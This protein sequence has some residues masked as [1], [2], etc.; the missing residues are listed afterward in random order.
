MITGLDRVPTPSAAPRTDLDSE[1]IERA[2]KGDTTALNRLVER[3]Y[4]RAFN[5]ALRLTGN[6]EDA[7]DVVSEA[8]IRVWR[9]L[10]RFEGHSRFTTW[11]YAVV[12]NVFL[13]HYKRERLRAHCSLEALV[14]PEG[15]SLAPQIPDPHPGPQEHV[16]ELDVRKRVWGAVQRLPE[17]YRMMIVLYHFQNLEYE[18]I[19]RILEMPVGTV[20]SRMHRA[21]MVLKTRI[22]RR[23]DYD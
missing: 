14:N 13:D 20:K 23:E 10:P 2:R 1:L 16:E 8:F 22:G 7:Q 15:E 3:H 19:A 4:P 21:R 12:K 5:L 18:E 17:P 6:H 9:A 11:L